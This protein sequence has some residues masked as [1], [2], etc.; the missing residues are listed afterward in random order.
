MT[1]R[2][3]I[4]LVVVC[5]GVVGAIAAAVGGGLFSAGNEEE[6]HA[7]AFGPNH[8]QIRRVAAALK[9][10]SAIAL[11]H[12]IASDARRGLEPAAFAREY[13]ANQRR[14][15]AVTAVVFQWPA[16]SAVTSGGRLGVMSMRMAYRGGRSRGYRAYFVYEGGWKL[17]FT[18]PDG[19]RG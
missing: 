15:G 18:E 6:R 13:R 16:R 1:T 9:R 3:R 8:P 12:V 5:F 4:V 7:V 14:T 17:W 11:Y 10:N 2:K 19:S